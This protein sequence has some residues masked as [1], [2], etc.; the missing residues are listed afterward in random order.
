MG[1]KET[2]KSPG[3]HPTARSHHDNRSQFL[4]KKYSLYIAFPVILQTLLPVVLCFQGL[5]LVLL[6]ILWERVNAAA[7]LPSHTEAEVAFLKL[8]RVPSTP[9]PVPQ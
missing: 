5:L 8:T 6:V 2:E 9:A 7:I 3:S 1:S 4:V